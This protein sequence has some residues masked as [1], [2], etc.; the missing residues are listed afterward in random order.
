MMAIA[1]EAGA[2]RASAK[3]LGLRMP[4]PMAL[5]ADRLIM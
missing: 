2:G 4:A 3:A 5:R 1:I